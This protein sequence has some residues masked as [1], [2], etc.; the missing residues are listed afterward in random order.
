MQIP[1]ETGATIEFRREIGATI[2]EYWLLRVVLPVAQVAV[3]HIMLRNFEYS[4]LS[5][6]SH[7]STF[8]AKMV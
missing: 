7:G 2:G 1:S 6:A 8:T 4:R 3:L 5:R